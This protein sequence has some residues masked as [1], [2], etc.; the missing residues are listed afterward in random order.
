MRRKEVEVVEEEE[1]DDE[2]AFGGT[3]GCK[4]RCASLKIFATS[5]V[6]MSR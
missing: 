2:V 5:F 6:K 3:A 1:D 4:R